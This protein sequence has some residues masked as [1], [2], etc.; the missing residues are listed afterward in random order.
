MPEIFPINPALRGRPG[1]R[2]AD[3]RRDGRFSAGLQIGYFLLAVR[4]EGLV[5][6]PMAGFDGEAIDKEFF[7]DGR[8]QVAA[9]GQHRPPGRE[10][11]VPPPAP[12]LAR[13]HGRLGLRCFGLRSAGS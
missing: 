12:A 4:A 7:P 3:A 10:S 1:G 2:A 6:G 11:L 5:A 9:R 8:F 13:R